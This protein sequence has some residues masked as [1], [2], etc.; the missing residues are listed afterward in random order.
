MKKHILLLAGMLFFGNA[1]AL[2]GEALDKY[3]ENKLSKYKINEVYE[4]K[5]NLHRTYLGED[6]TVLELHDGYK[7]YALIN[8]K[9]KEMKKIRI[10][11]EYCQVCLGKEIRYLETEIGQEGRVSD[12]D[13]F[14]IKKDNVHVQIYQ[15]FDYIEG[16]SKEMFTIID[17]SGKLI[18]SKRNIAIKD[19]YYQ[20]RMNRK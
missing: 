20:K 12:K 2:E 3:N 11:S 19:I 14:E 17:F 1:M 9:T 7:T 18:D 8:P 6:W 13:I 16:N 4:G 5:S 15:D 10:V